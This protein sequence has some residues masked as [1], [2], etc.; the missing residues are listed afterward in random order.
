MIKKQRF[1]FQFP[2]E[3]LADKRPSGFSKEDAILHKE[4]RMKKSRL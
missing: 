2:V 3:N 4:S 1:Y